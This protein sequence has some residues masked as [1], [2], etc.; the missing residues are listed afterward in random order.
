MCLICGKL[1]CAQNYCCQGTI[2]SDKVGSIT[3][4]VHKCSAGVG[5]LLIVRE[6]RIILRFG[7]N[8]GCF[9]S[10]PYLDEH[11]ETDEGLR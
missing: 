7:Q 1:V 5:I 8:R 11:G 9:Y 3:S 4:H 6:C 10:P 2:G